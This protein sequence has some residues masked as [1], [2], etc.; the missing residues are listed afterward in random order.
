M[1][2]TDL[3]RTSSLDLDFLDVIINEDDATEED[4]FVAGIVDAKIG[5]IEPLPLGLPASS[6]LD[7]KSVVDTKLTGAKR[8][9]SASNIDEKKGEK[10]KKQGRR[11]RGAKKG[12]TMTKEEKKKLRLL[13]NRQ[14]A[15]L[16]RDR[17]KAYLEN[18]ERRVKDLDVENKGLKEKLLQVT[19]ENESLKKKFGLLPKV[20]DCASPLLIDSLNQFTDE[21]STGITGTDDVLLDLESEL[22]GRESKS[23]FGNRHHRSRDDAPTSGNESGGYTSDSSVA[24]PSPPRSPV[25]PKSF[26][27][28]FAFAC[29][30]VLFG[31]TTLLQQQQHPLNLAGLPIDA[32]SIS[33]LAL[34]A[35][36]RKKMATG[37]MLMGASDDVE[38]ESSEDL[39]LVSSTFE[40]RQLEHLASSSMLVEEAER[41]ASEGKAIAIWRDKGTVDGDDREAVVSAIEFLRSKGIPLLLENSGSAETLKISVQEDTVKP[42]LVAA[43]LK[44]YLERKDG[45]KQV[46]NSSLVLCPHAHGLI[47][48]SSV[49]LHGDSAAESSRAIRIAASTA[50]RNLRQRIGGSTNSTTANDDDELL[51]VVPSSSL[52]W[53]QWGK[54]QQQGGASSAGLYEIAC[55]MKSIRPIR[56]ST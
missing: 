32:L 15:Q 41:Q 30:F 8:S 33:G 27:M 4:A 13:R 36:P 11:R 18:L 28:L 52:H 51:V 17:K 24:T 25:G 31:G 1:E 54:T 14:S 42:E 34:D 23:I 2:E 35:V 44:T 10:K 39:A 22:N 46:S 45:E 9:R 53:G 50:P 40:E 47:A 49:V 21:I 6:T 48:S 56:S 29:S 12:P 55:K 43:F 38:Y 26:M 37:R 7:T 5:D 20:R 3:V 19:R 16:H